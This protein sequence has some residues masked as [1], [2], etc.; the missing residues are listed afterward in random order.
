MSGAVVNSKGDPLSGIEVTLVQ[1]ANSYASRYA[2]TDVAR[3]YLVP[4]LYPGIL[5][6]D[7]NVTSAINGAFEIKGLLPKNYL[8]AT[9]V[10]EFSQFESFIEKHYPGTFDQAMAQ[11]VTVHAEQTTNSIDMSFK[12]FSAKLPFIVS[13]REAVK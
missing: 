7:I 1:Y 2:T 11:P 6:D 4:S 5:H 3:H 10:P 8:I 12:G 13:E 9:R